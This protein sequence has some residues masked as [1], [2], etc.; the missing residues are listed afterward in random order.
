MLSSNLCVLQ[1]TA[2]TNESEQFEW[3]WIQN[4]RLFKNN[5]SEP[6]SQL[7]SACTIQSSQDSVFLGAQKSLWR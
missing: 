1:S 7:E 5:A 6:F 2:N 3:F 4:S